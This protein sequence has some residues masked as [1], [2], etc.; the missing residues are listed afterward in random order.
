M[1]DECDQAGLILISRI[2]R[3]P[4]EKF[5]DELHSSAESCDTSASYAAFFEVRNVLGSAEVKFG[6][7]ETKPTSFFYFFILEIWMNVRAHLLVPPHFLVSIAF[8]KMRWK[9]E[10]G[11][12]LPKLPLCTTHVHRAYFPASQL[13]NLY[14][15]LSINTNENG[16]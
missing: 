15:Y 2:L 7:S 6:T 10:F 4:Y 1:S 5:L 8:K 9:D 13:S 14:L 11:K 12:W 3:F 16:A